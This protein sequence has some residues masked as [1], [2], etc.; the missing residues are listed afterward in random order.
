MKKI[1]DLLYLADNT[2]KA[3]GKGWSCFED[4]CM[5]RELK[6]LPATNSTIIKWM[7]CQT[8]ETSVATMILFLQGIKKV[9]AVNGHGAMFYKNAD[10]EETQKELARLYGKKKRQ[11]E[12]LLAENLIK[13]F[14]LPTKGD[15]FVNVAIRDKAMLAI[16][17]AAALRRSEICALRLNDIEFVDKNKVLLNIRKSK[18]DQ[19]GIGYQIPILDGKRVQPIRQLKRY[20]RI[21]NLSIEDLVSEDYLFHSLFRGGAVKSTP[22]HHTDIARI[23]KYYVE[24]IGLDPSKYSAHSLRAGFITSAAKVE[25]RLDKIMEISRHKTPQVVM[26]YIRDAD[27]FKNH[28]GAS[29]L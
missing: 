22:L 12:P 15:S 26:D 13:I 2:R 4:F 5:R 9:H 25:A 6:P 24:K 27:K 8:K 17:F 16:G 28:A 10:I 11:V 23:V 1:K 21:L 29:F 20:L 14:A 7:R 18:T 3:Y 19:T